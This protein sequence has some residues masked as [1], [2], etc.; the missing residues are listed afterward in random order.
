MYRA[1][2]IYTTTLEH[3]LA[4]MFKTSHASR[5]W[6][7]PTKSH[8]PAPPPLPAV[9]A[10]QNALYNFFFRAPPKNFFN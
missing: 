8:A 1:W 10:K 7:L 2:Y 6:W 4:R 3:I 5:V 9:A